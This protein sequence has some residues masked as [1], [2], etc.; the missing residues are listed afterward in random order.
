MEKAH[1][2][3]EQ[4]DRYIENAIEIRNLSMA[5]TEGIGSSKGY[6]RDIKKRFQKV[7]ELSK[8]N[9]KILKEELYPILNSQDVI[10]EDQIEILTG[11]STS[12]Q[13]QWPVED[14]DLTLV[15][16]VTNRLFNNALLR[17]E[18]E[19]IVR[20]ANLLIYAA[21][22]NMNRVNRIKRPENRLI[23]YY[24][25]EG[26][27]AAEVVLSYLEH[28]R[29]LR[30]T[31]IDR[32]KEV[33]GQARFYAALYDTYDSTDETVNN[34]RI[35][36][37]VKTLD[38]ADDSFYTQNT[39]G[40]DWDRYRLRSLEHMG[41]LTENG[42]AW[43]MTRHQCLK[44]YNYV[45]LLEKIWN[46]DPEKSKEL[47]PKMHLE[48]IVAR[49]AFFA[50]EES[51][52][53]YR[54]NLISIY[55]NYATAE[56]DMYSTMANIY[57]P[58]E[59]LATVTEDNAYLV[60]D[61]LSMFY[62]RV[63]AYILRATGQGAFSFFMEYIVT[64]LDRFIELQ[65]GMSFENMCLSCMAALH[66]PVF[67]DSLLTA[68]LSMYI[69]KELLKNERSSL[70]GC[71]L[72][73]EFYDKLYHC[74]L[75][76]DVG[77]LYVM[78]TLINLGRTPTKDEEF[79]VGLHPLAAYSLLRRHESTE[80]YAHIVLEHYKD[81]A[82][83]SDYFGDIARKLT[84]DDKVI[85]AIIDIA[86][87][88]MTKDFSACDDSFLSI[89][90]QSGSTEGI[91][92]FI[93]KRRPELYKTVYELL[94]DIRKSAPSDFNIILDEYVKRT[95]RIRVLSSPRISDVTNAS[96]YEEILT[97]NF[98]EIRE[99]SLENRD[100]LENML[101]PML[102]SSSPLSENEEESLFEFCRELI[103]GQQL[104]DLDCQLLHMITKRLLEEAEKKDDDAEKI[105][106]LDMHFIACYELAHQSKRMKSAVSLLDGYRIEGLEVARRMAEYL[107]P[108]NFKSLKDP[109]SKKLILMHSR[110]DTVMYEIRGLDKYL[111]EESLSTLRRSLE[112]SKDPLYAD[113]IS[114]EDWNYHCLRALEYIGQETECG[115]IRGFAGEDLGIIADHMDRLENLWN[116]DKK[117]NSEILTMDGL[118]ILLARNRYLA[119]RLG[120]SEYRTWLLEI[121]KRADDNDFEFYSVL[122]NVLVPLEY[123]TTLG[124]QEDEL[125]AKERLVLLDMYENLLAYAL[126]ATGVDNYSLMLEYFAEI[127][128]NFREFKG[129]LS[130]EEMGLRSLA[131]LHPPTY[132]HSRM[133][134]DISRLICQAMLDN[135]PS[136]FRGA[137]YEGKNRAILSYVY[138]AAICHDFGKLPMIDTISVYGRKLFDSEFALLKHHPQVGYE[139][140]LSHDSTKSYA[141]AALCHHVWFDES[142]GYPDLPEKIEPNVKAYID[143]ISIA[144]SIDAATDTIGRSYTTGKSLE[145]ILGEIAFDSGSR[146]SDRISKVIMLPDVKEKLT[147]LLK[148]GRRK[149]YKNAFVMMKNKL[150]SKIT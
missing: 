22:N 114:K 48:L 61:V 110:Y 68:D 131:A 111:N 78:D 49:N 67:V 34:K 3:K 41:Q 137:L 133:V 37:L 103:N 39:P 143:I 93:K 76:Y 104:G 2:L 120:L 59:Y 35:D 30:L 63:K 139:L 40:M 100:F 88:F 99:L 92:N 142:R 62:T 15:F 10:L 21:Y 150:D 46:K 79:L 11:F 148:S 96:S 20:Q 57:V 90:K 102:T 70:E 60:A 89:L 124:N 138:H 146:Y 29:F 7:T 24:R 53:D 55:E 44:I 84:S 36:A 91:K 19:D 18:D 43:K 14:L 116:M 77:K 101:F 98:M 128:Y 45:Q 135:S 95:A 86:K 109:K 5:H 72:D 107:K 28:D 85:F 65:G 83:E 122:A 115:N 149:N 74:G 112:F 126:H 106:H 64:F 54:K 50:G 13:N 141:K 52:E 136:F 129:G 27:K 87:G 144:D 71:S 147:K 119:G 113:S 26:L 47:L 69:V 42:N 6:Y 31:S 33:L 145:E 16:M 118:E 23:A 140:L 58:V 56:Y 17:G 8:E 75:C 12:L 51:L 108:E 125:D 73:G 1:N 80:K 121:Y 25:E 105:R 94:M 117:G 66:P 97:E 9:K 81:T 132:V 127:L 38:I 4:L 134:A 82:E 130:F 32:R 123:I